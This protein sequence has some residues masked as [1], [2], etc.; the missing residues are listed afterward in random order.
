MSIFGKWSGRDVAVDTDSGTPIDLLT[1]VQNERERIAGLVATLNGSSTIIPVLQGSV[2]EANARLSSLTE[3]LDDFTGRIEAL[4]RAAASI[5]S[6]ENR[7]SLFEGSLER[8]DAHA[9]RTAHRFADMDGQRQ[10]LEQLVSLATDL[11]A[12]VDAIKH[13]NAEVAKLEHQVPIVRDTYQQ[14]LNEHAALTGSVESLRNTT[15]ALGDQAVAARQ[16]S[17]DAQEK[18]ETAVGTIEAL[19]RR[20][21]GLS[22]LELKTRD[23]SAQLQSL[24]ALAEHV[25]SKT[26]A[27]EHQ[28]Q[29]IEHALVESRKVTEMVWNME[30]QI[31]KLNEGSAVTARVEETVHKLEQLQ[32]DGVAELQEALSTRQKL[33]ETFDT[34]RRDAMELVQSVQGHIDHLA[35]NRS[36]IETLSERV[37]MAQSTLDGVEQRIQQLSTIDTSVVALGDKVEQTSTRFGEDPSSPAH[38]ASIESWRPNTSS[39]CCPRQTS[40]SCRR[41]K[42]PPRVISSA[43]ANWQ[44]CDLVR[45]S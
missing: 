22:E 18:I 27:L 17:Q 35:V 39:T 21:A 43:G 14:I 25:A 38:P 1:S 45:C 9:T 2:D 37:A 31:V 4:S 20:V 44:R 40:S 36:E 30:A 6:L 12:R 11:L 19:E 42:P 16:L 7:L 24:N 29:T 15:V 33:S 13:D 23:T 3:R 8:A 28:Q 26:K 41:R 5:D 32:R 34:Q 10:S